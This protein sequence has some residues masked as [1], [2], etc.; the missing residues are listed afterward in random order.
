MHLKNSYKM[1]VYPAMLAQAPL[2]SKLSTCMLSKGYP[3]PAFS[4][5][6][7]LPLSLTSDLPYWPLPLTLPLSVVGILLQILPL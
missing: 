7:T 1:K 2:P 5:L 3:G 4:P 6:P